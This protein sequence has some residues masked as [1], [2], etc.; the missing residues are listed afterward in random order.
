MA[1]R[2]KHAPSINDTACL[3][4]P[5]VKQIQRNYDKEFI[6]R[7]LPKP[8]VPTKV[9]NL[10]HCKSTVYAQTTL[11][12]V[13]ELQSILKAK[14]TAFTCT[15][16]HTMSIGFC[17]EHYNRMYTSLHAPPCDS[18]LTKPRKGETFSQHCSSPE[19]V[20]EYLS[21]ISAECSALT[22]ES[23]LCFYCYKYF[24]SIISQV[25]GEGKQLVSS[26]AS[27][28]IILTTLTSEIQSLQGKGENIESIDFYEMVMCIIAKNLIA[29]L[30]ADEA[31]L[32]STLYKSF[33][34]KVYSEST[35]Y[36]LCDPRRDSTIPQKW[37]VLSRLYR[38]FGDILTVTCRHSRYGTLLYHKNCDLVNALSA[39]L[40]R[41]K[42]QS[43]MLMTR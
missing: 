18:C 41:N 43:Q 27:L 19:V 42:S 33:V 15:S 8:P 40:G 11:V 1:Y 21:H 5:C 39:A 2:K 22:S 24:Q 30:K 14:V 28:E 23:R 12:T 37:W 16:E 29:L 7:W 20:N 36:T 6:P 38:H 32:L 34:D 17:R 26:A 3:C 25:K 4:L 9:C 35:K 13:E 10:E 31:V